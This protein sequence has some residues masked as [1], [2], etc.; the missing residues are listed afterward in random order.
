MSSKKNILVTGAE[1]QLGL[2]LK[3][4]SYSNNN[5]NF[6]FFTKKTL[7]ICVFDD[8]CSITSNKNFYLIINCA[9]YTNVEDAEKDNII[10]NEVN[11]IALSNLIKICNEKKIKLIHISTDYVFDGIKNDL[12]NEND[13]PNPI[14]VYGL[15]KYMGE[16]K[17]IESE[18]ENS[19][20]IR[21]S[22]L[23]STLSDNNFVMKILKKLKQK[24][25][26]EV[27]NIEHGTPTNA[28]DL[29]KD[30]IKIITSINFKKPVI[31]NYSNS[32][33]CSRIEFAQKIKKI[34]DSDTQIIGSDNSFSKVKRPK[35]SG[36]DNSKFMSAF[37]IEINNWDFSLA[38][39]LNTLKDGF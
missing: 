4:L 34:M 37:D 31:L 36:L 17:I 18:L 26:F 10:A 11:N 23:Y 21:T 16:K 13:T 25:S 32:G 5:L 6:N 9:A 19:L 12:Y 35:F 15:T 14:N 33:F 38:K 29:A 20:I 24:K 39:S 30:I 28:S 8:L 1:G 2:E 3:K 27:N 22:W 7:D